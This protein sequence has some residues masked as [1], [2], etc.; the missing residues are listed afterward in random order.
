MSKAT[1]G[2][3]EV[4]AYFRSNEKAMALLSEKSRASMSEGTRGRLPADAVEV[5]NKRSRT[6]VYESGATKALRDAAHAEAKAAREAAAKAG[7]KVG[8]RG[9]LPKAA[10]E[11]LATPKPKRVRKP[12]A[13]TAEVAE[14]VT[15]VAETPA[16]TPSE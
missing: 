6:K 12:K 15:E 16:E 1:V 5:F 10:R 9:P 2:A 8:E 7:I 13:A 3:G 11:A 14:P 4:R